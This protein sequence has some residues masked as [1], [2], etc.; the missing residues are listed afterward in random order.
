MIG[1]KLEILTMSGLSPCNDLL[2]QIQLPKLQTLDLYYSKSCSLQ[3]SNII[4]IVKSLS[5]L[6]L[7]TIR[8]DDCKLSLKSVEDLKNYLE[9]KGRALC[10][11]FLNAEDY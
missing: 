2:G 3:D 8:I 5:N 1:K 9:E 11:K 4:Q 10:L 6:N 7:L